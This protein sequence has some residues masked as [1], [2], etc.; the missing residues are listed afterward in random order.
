VPHVQIRN[1]PPKVHAT[2]KKR[3]AKKG[4]SLSEYLLQEVTELASVP[5]DEEFFAE[6]R[7]QPRVHLSEDP[8]ETI[9]RIRDSS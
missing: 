2:L 4:V 3:A 7:R 9:R 1:V 5:T 6:L 8:A